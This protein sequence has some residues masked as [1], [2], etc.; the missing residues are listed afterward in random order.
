MPDSHL[1]PRYRG[2][3]RAIRAGMYAATFAA[4]VSM[5]AWTPPILGPVIGVALT[6]T[7]AG[8]LS[9][10][11]AIALYGA[12]AGRY[13]IEWP[14]AWVA[15]GASAAYLVTLLAASFDGMPTYASRAAL[16]AAVTL[17]LI[18]RAC[19]L[20]AHAAALREAHHDRKRRVEG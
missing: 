11:S 16:S 17:A 9:V 7:W 3:L 13:R 19:E 2:A 4:A 18:Y 10:S 15:A 8:M 1:T 6:A 5:V 14:S 20:G 12:A